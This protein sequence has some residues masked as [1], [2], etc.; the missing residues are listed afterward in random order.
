V[1]LLL[2]DPQ[3]RYGCWVLCFTGLQAA[4]LENAE[5]IYQ[6]ERDQEKYRIDNS[7]VFDA[8]RDLP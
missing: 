8:H 2:R 6:H 5:Q 1:R 7:P 4:T 3:K